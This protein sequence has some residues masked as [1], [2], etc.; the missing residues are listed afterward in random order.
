M[1]GGGVLLGGVL[2][3]EEDPPAQVLC[4][5]VI[6]LT[7]QRAHSDAAV[8]AI[9][10]GVLTPSGAHH[11][12]SLSISPDSFHKSRQRNV[13]QNYLPMHKTQHNVVDS[14]HKRRCCQ[15]RCRGVDERHLEWRRNV[16]TLGRKHASQD[17]K[18]LARRLLGICPLKV[19]CS[20]PGHQCRQQCTCSHWSHWARWRPR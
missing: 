18:H 1:H 14:R 13:L 3:R 12:Q 8:A 7:P 17:L 20:V 11:L 16:D 9:R 15:V 2:P 19:L 4:Q 6:L 5:G 10:H